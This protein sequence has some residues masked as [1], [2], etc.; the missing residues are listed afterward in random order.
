MI[1]NRTILFLHQNFPGQF[2]HLCAALAKRNRVLFLSR[3]SANRL[4]GVQLLEDA[5][6]REPDPRVHPYLAGSERAV[7]QGQATARRLLALRA[8]GI[9]PDLVIGHTG[10]GETLFVKDVFP[11]VP[12]LSYFEFFYS[13]TGADVGFDPEFPADP[14]AAFRLRIRNQG[15]LSCL[16]ATDRGLSPTHWQRSRLPVAFQTKIGVI[17]DG[18]DTDIA[19][20]SPAPSVTL[21]DGTRLDSAV[22][23]VT[24]VARNLEPYRGFHIF[25]RAARSILADHPQA[26]IVVVGGDDVSYGA[27]LPEGETYRERALREAPIDLSR[28]HFT[29][30]LPYAIYLTLLQ[31]SRAHVYLTYPFVLSWSVLEA[32]ATGCLVVASDTAPV[33]EV[34]EDGVNGRLVDF[35]DVD[36]IAERV[37]EAL[38]APE[39]F[40]HIGEAARQ[41]ILDRYDLKR[42]CLPRQL[43]LLAE[44]I[45]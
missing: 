6:H 20:P 16:E 32:M 10:W 41:A 23:V 28:V 25:L 7:L 12:L 18:V 39:R 35:F 11:D 24:Y 42:V 3:K 29:G 33:R 19:R 21:P 8:G 4:P 17:H 38:R 2:R 34:I 31:V 36:G 26:R 43:T 27:R 44:M 40:R 22:P 30:R 5:P 13:A 37:A 9:R 1:E 14:D 45:G 15:L